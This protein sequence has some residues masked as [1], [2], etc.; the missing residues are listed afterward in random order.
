MRRPFTSLG[1]T[2]E[3]ASS[4]MLQAMIGSRR[5]A[6]LILTAGWIDADSALE[7][8]IATCKLKDNEPLQNA[9][10]KAAEMVE[11]PRASLR[12]AERCLILARKTGIEAALLARA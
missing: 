9:V 12:E 10:A 7:S 5:A 1:I 11:L 4:Y 3:F 6:E 2:S 8:G